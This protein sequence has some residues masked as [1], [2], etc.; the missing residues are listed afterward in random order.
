MQNFMPACE[1]SAK[2]KSQ[3]VNFHRN[4]ALIFLTSVH[5]SRHLLTSEGRRVSGLVVG[6]THFL[7][8]GK[9]ASGSMLNEKF[10]N[11]SL[12]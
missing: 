10:G 6:K 4:L 12:Q 1:N 8:G 3:N 9:R 11:I 2:K 5:D 7:L